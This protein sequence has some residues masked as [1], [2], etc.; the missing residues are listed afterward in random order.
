LTPLLLLPL[1][2]LLRKQKFYATRDFIDAMFVAEKI[3]VMP[4]RRRKW[5]CTP[6]VYEQIK[7]LEQDDVKLGELF[8]EAEW[9]ESDVKSLIDRLEIDRDQ[10]IHLSIAQR[11]RV[12]CTEDIEL[13]RLAKVL[14]LEVVDRDEFLE[15]YEREDAAESTDNLNESE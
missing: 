6:D 8:E 7:D 9:S 11:C 2:L 1:L 13:R 12:F 3:H 4:Q 15:R 5:L 14:E 10:A